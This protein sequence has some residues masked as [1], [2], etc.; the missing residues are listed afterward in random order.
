MTEIIILMVYYD[1]YVTFVGVD[2]ETMFPESWKKKMDLKQNQEFEFD[3]DLQ[4]ND[5]HFHENQPSQKLS[6]LSCSGREWI[7]YSKS[8]SQNVATKYNF[9][10]WT[11]VLSSFVFT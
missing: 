10:D 8:S 9:T 3:S 7:N 6:E 2:R 11:I 1:F 4:R 5:S